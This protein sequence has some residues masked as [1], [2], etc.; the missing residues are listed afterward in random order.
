MA[1]TIVVPTIMVLKK[2]NIIPVLLN[3]KLTKHH[4]MHKITRA[5]FAT[6]T[7]GL[8]IMG[9][10]GIIGYAKEY[11]SLEHINAVVTDS[12]IVVKRCSN[13]S[14]TASSSSCHSVYYDCYYVEVDY[15]YTMTNRKYNGNGS[16]YFGDLASTAE[17]Y[18]NNTKEGDDIEIWVYPDEPSKSSL[19]AM[20]VPANWGIV[21]GLGFGLAFVTLYCFIF[22]SIM[23][24]GKEIH[25]TRLRV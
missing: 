23:L 8:C 1:E 19:H 13:C 12:E 21:I 18:R 11:D 6:T 7:I 24:S 17:R 4:I 14:P 20:E 5:V 3:S 16:V 22:A 10:V 9:F 2:L 25:N 15:S